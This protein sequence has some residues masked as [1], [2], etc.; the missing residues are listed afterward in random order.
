[1]ITTIFS[2]LKDGFINI[3]TI[4]IGI[5]GALIAGYVVSENIKRKRA[6]AKLIDIQNKVLKTQVDIIKTEAKIATE[7]KYI[8]IESHKQILDQLEANKELAKLEL[9][10][11]TSQMTDT[12]KTNGK[13]KLFSFTGLTSIKD[14]V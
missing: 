7:T 4:F 11:I 1:M 10:K 5:I 9:D 12:A 3:K 2:S 6:E 13:R 14:K 8:E